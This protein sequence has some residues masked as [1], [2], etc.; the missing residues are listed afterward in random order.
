M[1]TIRVLVA[2]DD[3]EVRQALAH[4]ID[5]H[6]SLELVGL[7]GDANEAIDLASTSRPDVVVLDVRMPG[8]GGARAAREIRRHCPDVRIVALSAHDDERSV[9]D[10]LG[11][12]VTS[13]LVKGAPVPEILRAIQLAVAGQATVSDSIT[14][15]LVGELSSRLDRERQDD[16]RV[17]EQVARIRSILDGHGGLTMVFQPI[18]DLT[19]GMTVGTEA[20]ARFSTDPVRPPDQWFLEAAEVGLGNELELSAVRLALN[21]FPVLPPDAFLSVNASPEVASGHELLSE[22]ERVPAGR[23]VIEI[24]EHAPVSDYA[25]L[26]S[27][28]RSARAL[29]ARLAIDDAGAGF[30][31]LRH[32]LQ[33]SPD[34]I[35][36]DISITRGI[37][38]ER[39]N[40][41]LAAS[42]VTFASEIG[43]D[44]VAEGIE[45]AEELDA[46]RD[47]GIRLGQG[48]FLGR[49][50]ALP[51]PQLQDA[52]QDAV[53]TG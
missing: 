12:G 42:L 27:A 17:L 36:L 10:M 37:D 7:A 44:L 13:Y 39:A 3:E 53:V 51:A 35:K 43:A 20:L 18:V 47:M 16:A 41:A 22:L 5:R 21:A 38:T 6:D 50:A 46:L 26:N 19:T 34:L 23:A 28:L 9:R 45:S 15:T 4:L 11:G 33:L 52:G 8:G 2:D 48:Y 32:I 25:A 29:G 24:T 30:A 31:S 14:T 1:G 49:P 40:R